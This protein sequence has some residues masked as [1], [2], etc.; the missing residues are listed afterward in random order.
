MRIL[1]WV[2]SQYVLTDSS[3]RR[4]LLT[5]TRLDNC[6]GLVINLVKPV[7]EPFFLFLG[8]VTDPVVIAKHENVRSDRLQTLRTLG[9]ALRFETISAHIDFVEICIIDVPAGRALKVHNTAVALDDAV[10][11]E[12]SLFEVVVNIAREHEVV[13]SHVLLSDL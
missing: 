7:S 5:C 13:S 4:N 6:K 10:L 2:P 11:F 3:D 1:V 8:P 9:N 12:A